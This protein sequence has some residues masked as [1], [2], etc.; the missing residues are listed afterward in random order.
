MADFYQTGMV[1]T[2][3]RLHPNGLDRIE[4]ELEKEERR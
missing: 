4:G 3:H 1:S 2:L